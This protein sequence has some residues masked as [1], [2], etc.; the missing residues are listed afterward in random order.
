MGSKKN[1]LRAINYHS[2]DSR[3]HWVY[4]WCSIFGKDE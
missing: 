1:E 4:R 2:C 3:T